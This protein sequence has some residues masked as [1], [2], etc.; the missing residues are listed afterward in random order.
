Y[1]LA[2]IV[3]LSAPGW[4]RDPVALR[5]ISEEAEVMV[6]CAAGFYW[7]PFP[8]IAVNGSME[9]L[10]DAM[11]EEVEDGADGTGVRCGVIKVGTARGEPGH[12]EERLFCA[13]AAASKSTG[14][15]LITHTSSPDQ[16][17]WHVHVLDGAGMDM[18]RVVI[19]H[20]G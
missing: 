7:D 5:R 17:A 11:I 6:V 1:G 13:A 15:A 16:A 18:S 19:S 4:G 14:A 9:R 20:M 8:D 2:A 12:V 10:R 3:D